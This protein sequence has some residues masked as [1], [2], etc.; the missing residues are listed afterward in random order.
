MR[1]PEKNLSLDSENK[2]LSVEGTD[3]SHLLKEPVRK[4]RGVRMLRSLGYLSIHPVT[5][6]VYVPLS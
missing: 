5:L 4:Q 2:F 3:I 1:V 6:N